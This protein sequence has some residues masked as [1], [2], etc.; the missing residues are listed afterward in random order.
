M[1]E[2]PEDARKVIL[3]SS[4]YTVI[5]GTLYYIDPKSEGERKIVVPNHL[6]KT[7]HDGVVPQ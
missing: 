1:A 6:R 4:L 2:K 3:Q 7:V 5:D